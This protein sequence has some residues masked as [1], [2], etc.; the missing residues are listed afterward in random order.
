[1]WIVKLSNSRVAS[2]SRERGARTCKSKVSVAQDRNGSFFGDRC[3]NVWGNG[4][5]QNGNREILQSQLG[6]VVALPGG[7]TGS[8]HVWEGQVAVLLRLWAIKLQRW[9]FFR[10]ETRENQG[11]L[12]GPFIR[13]RT[14]RTQ[15]L[16][17]LWF[18]R[19]WKKWE[20]GGQ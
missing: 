6:N 14:C 11:R 15:E 7:S 1:M 10:V 12:I 17:L 8:I 13:T 20:V 2:S 19:V 3:I 16:L 9:W 18:D 4:D 5:K